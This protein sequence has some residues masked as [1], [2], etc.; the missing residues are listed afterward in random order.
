MVTIS[1]WYLCLLA[2][3]VAGAGFGAGASLR[4]AQV[5]SAPTIGVSE[6]RTGV[7]AKILE[8]LPGA[9]LVYRS[10]GKIVAYNAPAQQLF[11]GAVTAEQ[12][13]PSVL[14]LLSTGSPALKVVLAA[15]RDEIVTMNHAGED[16]VFYVSKR[17]IWTGKPNSPDSLSIVSAQMITNSV[18][19]REVDNW[20]NLVRT[21]AHEINNSLAPML[22]LMTSATKL[23]Q[24]YSNAVRLCEIFEAVRE[25]GEHL[26][27]FL[28]AYSAVARIPAAMKR[29]VQLS[30]VAHRMRVLYPDIKV[31][32]ATPEAIVQIDETQFEQVLINLVSNARDAGS[33]DSGIEVALGVQ[34]DVL[35]IAVLDQGSG[36]SDEALGAA[37]VPSFSTKSG[38]LGIGLALS[39][40]IVELHA[41]RIRV[42]NRKL[43]GAEVSIVIALSETVSPP[44][45]TITV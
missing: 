8:A 26:G 36:F 6:F 15:E 39:R 37:F 31:E 27:S 5:L 34:A 4:R 1:I 10:D 13:L 30:D 43:R 24:G 18:H 41:G 25:R 17:Q 28:R 38:G 12:A 14:A 23:V 42:Q 40:E 45:F 21:L 29:A 44:R 2:I 35:R 33:A 20:K 3:T 19:R 9:I 32:C 11:F 7:A 22:S 16:E